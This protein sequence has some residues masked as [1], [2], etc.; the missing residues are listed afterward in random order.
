MHSDMDHTLE[1][2]RGQRG[3]AA[4]E[5]AKQDR[6]TKVSEA[7][8]PKKQPSGSNTHRSKKAKAAK[9][10]ETVTEQLELE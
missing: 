10:L 5:A 9:A 8:K 1:K 2:R 4:I 7:P 3:K 6:E